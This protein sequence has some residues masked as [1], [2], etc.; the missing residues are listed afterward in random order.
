MITPN[1]FKEG[2]IFEDDRGR[3]LQVITYQRHRKS[4]SR[5]KVVTK[6]RDIDSGGVLERSYPSET[7]LREIDVRK[8]NFQ[9]LYADGESL[10]FMD[11]GTYEQVALPKERLG[12]DV[13]YLVDNMELIGVYMDEKFRTVELP[14]NVKVKVAS[15]EPGVRG[16]SVSNLT[17]NATVENGFD[18]K[19]PLFINEGDVIKIDTRTG[20][21][22]ERVKE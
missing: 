22:I 16:D 15:S 1:D 7:K 21:Y 17:K 3:R 11:N 19:V 13:K 10:H 8:R 9:F 5:A 20:Q 12:E 2:T 6:V 4:Q 18:V 14:P